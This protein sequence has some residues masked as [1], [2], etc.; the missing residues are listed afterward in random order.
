MRNPGRIL[1]TWALLGLFTSSP[2]TAGEAFA[3]IDGEEVSIEEFERFVYAA[4]RKTFYHGSPLDEQGIIEFRRKAAD[5]L[6]DRK[7]KLREAKLRGL[8]ADEKLIDEQLAE[9]EARYA[10][11]E[12]WQADS[13]AIRERLRA[14][15]EDENL[16]Q[17][18][19]DELREVPDPDDADLRK[20]YDA[21][22]EK[23]TQPEQVR[24]SVIL[25]RVPPSAGQDVWDEVSA[26]AE[27]IAARILEGSDFAEEARQHSDDLTAEAGGDMGFVHEGTLGSDLQAALD[28]LAPG[29][30]TATPIR[31]L[32][33]MVVAKLV[34]RRPQATVPLSD[35]RER[36]LT[37]YKREASQAAYEERLDELR[38]RSEIW[39]DESVLNKVGHQATR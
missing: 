6:I 19:D 27:S 32:E 21:N 9:Y 26:E 5:D 4:S 31:V 18:I 35:A 34:D 25:L 15:L 22:I 16:H 38:S 37:L 12:Q 39:I 24:V 17:Q 28:A 23:F 7:L 11:T 20:F 10:A 2:A 33:G 3:T 30:I 36:A 14:W 1:V 8:S 13:E 29:E